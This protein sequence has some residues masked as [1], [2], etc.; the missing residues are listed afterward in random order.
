MPESDLI[1]TMLTIVIEH[2]YIPSNQQRQMTFKK[3]LQQC[4]LRKQIMSQWKVTDFELEYYN[5]ILQTQTDSQDVL[6]PITK[7]LEMYISN[8][9]VM[10]GH[11][12]GICSRCWRNDRL[13]SR[14][15]F[16]FDNHTQGLYCRCVYCRF[17]VV[18]VLL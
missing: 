9:S 12:A 15:L 11:Y 17:S 18:H 8:I 5:F 3:N 4:I 16:D 14:L 7:I 2:W 13:V 10:N 1:S 6:I